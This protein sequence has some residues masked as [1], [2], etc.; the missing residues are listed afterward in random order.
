AIPQMGLA[1]E[2][3]GA[4]L[5]GAPEHHERTAIGHPGLLPLAAHRIV[6]QD[7]VANESIGLLV[8]LVDRAALGDRLDACAS[9]GRLV[10]GISVEGVPIADPEIQLVVFLDA[11]VSGSARCSRRGCDGRGYE[12]NANCCECRSQ[13][14]TSRLFAH[15][16]VSPVSLVGRTPTD[17]RL[18]AGL[19]AGFGHY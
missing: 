4:V 6:A 19:L 8:E 14:V 10:Q 12:S 9:D 1:F 5:E 7:A 11:A 18:A 15:E 3:Q 16:S 17:T 13:S 2:N